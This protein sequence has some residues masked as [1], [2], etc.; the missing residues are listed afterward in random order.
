MQKKES[1]M[2]SRAP[3]L[4]TSLLF[5]GVL[6]VAAQAQAFT[7]ISVRVTVIEPP[8]CTINDDNVIE[9]DFG[10]VMTTR[11]DGDAYRRAINYYVRCSGLTSNALTL[12][13]QGAG[14]AFDGGALQTNVSDLGIALYRDRE[15]LP[16]NQALNFTYPDVP[17]LYAAPVKRPGA[18]LSGGKFTAGATL[19]VDYQ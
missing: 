12:Q 5:G 15:R 2:K 13:F 9:V 18:T 6:F 7:P 4:C 14:T 11:V 17:V 8:S 1:V 19:R 10:E 16:L 3:G